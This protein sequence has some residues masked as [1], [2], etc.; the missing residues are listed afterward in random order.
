MNT[1]AG[2]GPFDAPMPAVDRQDAL[3]RSL[4]C[5][6]T[7]DSQRNLTRVLA[8]FF[9]DAFPLDQKHLAD[10]GEVEVRIERRTAP[11]TARLDAAMLARRDRDEI[12]GIALLEQQPDIAFQRGLVTLDAEM[13]MRLLRNQVGGQCALGQQGIA[14]DVLACDVTALKQQDRHADLVSALMLITTGYG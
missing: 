2:L 7:R 1:V 5:S 11:N 10:V 6:A 13:I 8:G 9:L 14:R 3:R 12:S 4:L